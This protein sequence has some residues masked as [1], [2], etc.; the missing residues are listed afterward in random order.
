[1]AFTNAIERASE[2]FRE[3]PEDPDRLEDF[4]A[5]VTL[6]RDASL[7]ID[8]RRAQNRYYRLRATVRP[9]IEAS[10]T[11]SSGIARMARAFDK[12]GEKLSIAAT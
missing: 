10:A 1:M 7:T 12:L 4:D 5:I 11:I 8:L 6:V 3:R 2:R 9:A